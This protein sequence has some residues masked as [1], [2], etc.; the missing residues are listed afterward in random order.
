M[1]HSVIELEYKTNVTPNERFLTSNTAVH[2]LMTIQSYS[3]VDVS[4]HRIS[5]DINYQIM[6]CV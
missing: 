2:Y 3:A 5:C 6:Y 1:H 4:A